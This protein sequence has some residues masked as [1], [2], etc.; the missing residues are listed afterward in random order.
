MCVC[1]GGGLKLPAFLPLF[2]YPL[3]LPNPSTHA[4]RPSHS[5]GVAFQEQTKDPG[6]QWS[7][8]LACIHSNFHVVNRSSH[9]GTMAAWVWREVAGPSPLG[10]NW[11]GALAA[12][13]PSPKLDRSV[14]VMRVSFTSRSIA[15]WRGYAEIGA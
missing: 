7:E 1:G 5:P 10:E 11:F 9:R 15:R 14:Y 8:A 4:S 3:P 12:S 13:H 2:T 6:F